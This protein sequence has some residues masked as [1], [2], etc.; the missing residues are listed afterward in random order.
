VDYY[1]RLYEWLLVAGTGFAEYIWTACGS[2]EKGCGWQEGS[3]DESQKK[4]I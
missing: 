4:I 2:Q 3:K 1:D